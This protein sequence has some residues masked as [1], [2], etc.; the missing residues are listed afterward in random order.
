MFF[1]VKKEFPSVGKV[2]WDQNRSIIGK[3]NEFIAQ[4]GENFDARMTSYFEYFKKS[5]KQRM[6]IPVS[7]VEQHVKDILFLMDIDYTYI[8]AVIPR[9]RWLRPLGYELDVDQSSTAITTFLVEKTDK[10]TKHFGTYDVVKSRVVT[11]L[12]IAR[13]I[14]RKDKLVKKLKKKFGADIGETGTAEEVE[15]MSDD[16]EEDDNEKEEDEPEQGPLQLIQGLGED[17]DESAE[18]EEAKE[19]PIRTKV[20]KRKEKAPPTP[21]PKPKKVVKSAPKKTTTRA[22]TSTTTQ[23]RKKKR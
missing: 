2:N 3:I 6:R 20:T 16:E 1:Y 23:L 21:Q 11:D 13:V 8:Q 10:T 14:K 18:E 22:T 4:M 7:L 19:A 5:M 15:E 9:V 12:K 17:K